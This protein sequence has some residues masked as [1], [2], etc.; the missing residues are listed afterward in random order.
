MAI[1]MGLLP[2]AIGLFSR[3]QIKQAAAQTTVAEAL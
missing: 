3:R 1:A 2:A